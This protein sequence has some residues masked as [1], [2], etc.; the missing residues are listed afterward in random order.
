MINKTITFLYLQKKR[1]LGNTY[2][3]VGVVEGSAFIAT[4]CRAEAQGRPRC[5]PS[6]GIL[7]GRVSGYS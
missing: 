2:S 5:G 3:D 6:R 4:D 1:E 7:C